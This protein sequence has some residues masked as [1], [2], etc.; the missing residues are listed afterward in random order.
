MSC[1]E[2]DVREN[3]KHVSRVIQKYAKS[4]D[5]S[6]IE[7]VSLKV[8]L[9]G[10]VYTLMRLRD[11]E[12]QTLRSNSVPISEDFD[13]PFILQGR[14]NIYDSL[15]KM[16]VALRAVFGE[17]G[18]HYDEWKGS[19]SFPFLICFEKD[20]EEYEYVMNVFSFRSY[21][22]FSL[23]RPIAADD[24]TFLRG[25]YHE[26]FDDFPLTQIRFLIIYLVAYL[27]GVFKSLSTW[28]DT[29]FF[30]VIESNGIVYGY[31]KGEFFEED[32]ED[33][34]DEE[35][36]KS[37]DED[38]DES[39]LIELYMEVVMRMLREGAAVEDIP[40]WSEATRKQLEE[41]QSRWEE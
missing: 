28:Y 22:Q 3:A 30:H 4:H 17:S 11:H 18:S 10:N 31:R 27:T 38:F 12:Y 33:L 35:I 16:Y 2:Y 14:D 21:V 23:A 39:D 25:A 24:D 9:D 29:P 1:E 13:L 6:E 19:F 15:P 20:G 8:D 34:S 41:I 40:L 7:H 32:F 5:E 36:E 37:Q 26:P